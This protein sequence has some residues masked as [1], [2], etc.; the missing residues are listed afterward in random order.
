MKPTGSPGIGS[1]SRRQFGRQRRVSIAWKRSTSD[2]VPGAGAASWGVGMILEVPLLSLRRGD[3]RRAD[4]ELRMRRVEEEIAV[5]TI[6]HEVDEARARALRS[7]ELARRLETGLVRELDSAVA[8]ARQASDAGALDPLK[9]I[10][11]ELDQLKAERRLLEARYAHREAVID[12]EAAIGARATASA[13][14]APMR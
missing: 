2:S 14:A 8:L 13:P 1:T 9:V 10:D 12:L 6:V 11:L 4:A 7:G 5:A 3:V